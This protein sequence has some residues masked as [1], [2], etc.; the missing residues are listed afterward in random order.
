M[1]HTSRFM[2]GGVDVCLHHKGSGL[3][4]GQV[5]IQARDGYAL[6]TLRVISISKI[7]TYNSWD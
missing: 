1:V 3:K 2:L 7:I 6:S 5:N 4:V